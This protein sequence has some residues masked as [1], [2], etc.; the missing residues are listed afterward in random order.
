MFKKVLGN[1]HKD[2]VKCS[3]KDSRELFKRFQKIFLEIPGK[4]S[5]DFWGDYSRNF[6]GVFKMI[7]GNPLEDWMFY[8]T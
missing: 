1:V 6:Q 7:V 3:K 4:C 5:K 2:F 8:H